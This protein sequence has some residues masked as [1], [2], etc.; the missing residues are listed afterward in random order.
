MS[1]RKNKSTL[2]KEKD[3]TSSVKV[4]TRRLSSSSSPVLLNKEKSTVGKESGSDEFKRKDYLNITKLS[5]PGFIGKIMSMPDYTDSFL[6]DEADY[7]TGRY[8][9]SK[10]F[11]F[12]FF[13]ISSYMLFIQISDVNCNLTWLINKDSFRPPQDPERGLGLTPLKISWDPTNKE[14]SIDE[15]STITTLIPTLEIGSKI[16]NGFSV[17]MIL[18]LALLT[19]LDIN[20][21]SLTDVAYVMSKCSWSNKKILTP[22]LD[23]RHFICG[24]SIYNKFGFISEDDNST[25]LCQLTIST[26]LDDYTQRIYL[27]RDDIKNTN[28]SKSIY[29][30][31][32]EWQI[33]I[34]NAID[35]IAL[36][37]KE[38][39][40][41]TI[42]QWLL[43]F[44]IGDERNCHYLLLANLVENYLGYGLKYKGLTI[45]NTRLFILYSKLINNNKVNNK[46]LQT[47]QDILHKAGVKSRT[48][49]REYSS[50]EDS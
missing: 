8:K 35:I 18:A 26:I 15:V 28:I 30:N 13:N 1:S 19:K 6:G 48:L 24:G 33:R 7:I 10:L 2:L 50:L 27:L 29:K 25:E 36:L 40:D 38:S 39:K 41:M 3:S 47:Y 14:G 43:Q 21:A 5:Q 11:K 4:T 16:Y 32:A 34:D 37:S 45:S 23:M 44:K 42:G 12:K 46:I 9:N 49:T 31:K 22:L 17:C 20:I